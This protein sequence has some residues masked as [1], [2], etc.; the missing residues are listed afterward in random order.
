MISIGD[1]DS[2]PTGEATPQWSRFRL[3]EAMKALEDDLG[4]YRGGFEIGPRKLPANDR[5]VEWLVA[6]SDEGSYRLPVIPSENWLVVP[7]IRALTA[8]TL[9]TWLRVLL[10][11]RISFIEDAMASFV[12]M[13]LGVAHRAINHLR[14]T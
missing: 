14:A 12:I 9:V 5:H 10:A 3:R 1:S 13:V 2:R 6:S 4:A 11:I 7:G 8:R